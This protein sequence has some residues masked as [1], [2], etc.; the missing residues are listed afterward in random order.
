MTWEHYP[1]SPF[2]DIDI[3]DHGC[4]RSPSERSVRNCIYCDYTPAEQAAM[5]WSECPKIAPA[6]KHWHIKTDDGVEMCLTD[7]AESLS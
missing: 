1:H 2:G 6:V 4:T 7:Y 5:F 3:C